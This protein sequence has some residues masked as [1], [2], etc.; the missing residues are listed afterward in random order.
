[1]AKYRAYGMQNYIRL[2]GLLF[3][4]KLKADVRV[5]LAYRDMCYFNLKMYP[6]S[7]SA[8]NLPGHS[9]VLFIE[10]DFRLLNFHC[11]ILSTLI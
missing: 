1:M 7:F 6:N 2:S 5:L 3:L 8:R 9:G 10:V 4:V 11:K